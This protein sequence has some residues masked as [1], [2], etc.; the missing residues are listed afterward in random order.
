MYT[1]TRGLLVLFMG[2]MVFAADAQERKGDTLKR[3]EPVIKQGQMNPTAN[4]DGL[5]AAQKEQIEKLNKAK[6][7]VKREEKEF[8]KQ[9][10]KNINIRLE[11]GD[12]TA[13]EADKLKNEAASKRAKNIENRIQICKKDKSL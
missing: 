4:P 10:I 6:E 2:L 13:E 9:E 7:D 8:L 12:I 11:R 1:I 3:V 5:D